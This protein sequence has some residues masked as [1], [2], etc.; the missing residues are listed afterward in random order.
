[1]E[2][3][4]RLIAVANKGKVKQVIIGIH[5]SIVSFDIG[6]RICCGLASTISGGH[7][8]KNEPDVP[9]AGKL[10]QLKSEQLINLSLSE[11]PTLC[12][13]GVAALNALLPSSPHLWHEANAEEMLARY[14]KG[15]NVVMVGRFPFADRLK[16]RV[17]ELV[18]LEENPEPGDLPPN[19]AKDKLPNAELIAITGMA[20]INHTLEGLLELC[21]PEATVMLIGPSTP[22]SPILFDYGIDILS[23]AV[24]EKPESVMRVVA[25]GG[26]FKQVHQAGIRL[27]NIYT[28]G[29]AIEG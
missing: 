28:P 18:V 21:N 14:G 22:L 11:N 25:E 17:G 7:S 8:H 27:V 24:V 15:K 13:V 10:V 1:M 20:M 2:I 23:G 5:W 29:I 6:G 3:I 4:K 19:S 26:N 12:S 16:S 9:L